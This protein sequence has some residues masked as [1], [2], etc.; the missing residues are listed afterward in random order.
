[1]GEHYICPLTCSIQAHAPAVAASMYSST[2]CK[3]SM[4][5]Q[6]SGTS[7]QQLAPRQQWRVSGVVC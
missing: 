7:G 4:R 1:M 3:L 5:G 6:G 2:A